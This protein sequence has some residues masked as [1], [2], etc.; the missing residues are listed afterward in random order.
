MDASDE[1]TQYDAIAEQYRRSKDSPLRRHVEA[2]TFMRLLGDVRGKQVLDLACGEGFYARRI[3]AA[4][5]E[6]VVGV[7]VSREMIEL[8]ERAQEEITAFAAGAGPPLKTN[9]TRLRFD[10]DR[11][12]I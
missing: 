5:A 11:S 10:A 6:R 8:V 1:V 4:G 12:V 9:P 7:D 2:H 3:R